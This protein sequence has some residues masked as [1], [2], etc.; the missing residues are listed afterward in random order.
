MNNLFEFFKSSF[1]PGGQRRVLNLITVLVLLFC[2]QPAFAKPTTPTSDFIDNNDGTVTHKT[3]GLTWM[4]C[5]LGQTWTGSTCSGEAST[6]SYADA[7][8]LTS[9]FAGYSDW[10][11]PNIVELQTIVERRNFNP[12]INRTVFPS[13]PINEFWSSSHRSKLAWKVSCYSGSSGLSLVHDDYEYSSVRLVRAS[14]SL[15]IGLATP[16][17][18]FTDNQD[19][20]VTHKRTGLMWQRCAVG[21]TWTGST[22][23][24]TA[25]SYTYAV[26]RKVVSN[27]AG[28]SDWRI[29]NANEL[30]S[31]VSYDK[32][33]PSINLDQFPNT[34]QLVFWSS[35]P[36]V[37][38]S[39]RAWYVHFDYGSVDYYGG[40][41]SFP[42][43]L[44]RTSQS[45]VIGP[46]PTVDL[47]T[48]ISASTSTIKRN[49]NITYTATLTNSGTAAASNATLIFYFPSRW[50]TY[51]SVPSDCVSKGRSY[52]CTVPS[53][54]AGESLTKAITVN[55]SKRGAVNIVSLSTTDSDDA[56]ATNNKAQV[57]TSITP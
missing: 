36:Y 17:T 5:A 48:T 11:L 15:A 3:T 42:V 34:H 26:A 4:R 23:S 16:N 21:Q 13:T 44:V 35:S 14:Q 40:Y 6:Y 46:T 49:E 51:V 37:G 56:D 47:S 31:I 20:T 24:G 1:L 50:I 55:Y 10:R 18:E 9:T 38:G 30:V 57:M 53:L 28:Y 45:P 33:A 25:R 32:V 41:H 39:N 7:V 19:G 8:A 2:F 29:P 27:L 22:C 12:A 52:R 54:A 43:R